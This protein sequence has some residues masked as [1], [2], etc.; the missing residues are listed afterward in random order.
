M[1]TMSTK[2]AM[3]YLVKSGKTKYSI[4]VGIGA[5]PASAYQWAK[6]TKISVAYAELFKHAYGIEINDAV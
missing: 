1:K 3:A 5:A 4:A 2:Q 6:G